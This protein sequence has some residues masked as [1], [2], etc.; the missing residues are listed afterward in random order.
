MPNILNTNADLEGRTLTTAE[1]NY[2]IDGLH[3]FDRGTSAPFAVVAGAAK[4]SNLDAD[5]LDGQTGA[6]YHD[7]SLLTGTYAALSGASITTLNA[8]NLASGTVPTARL[9]SGTAN[10]GTVLRGDQTYGLAFGLDI[11]NLRLSLTTATPVTTANV[12]AATTVY[13]ALYRGNRVALYTGTVWVVVSVAELTVAVPA[14]TVTPFDIFLDYNDGTPALST[15][16]WTNDTT[17]ATALT[18]QDGVYVK[19]GDTQQRYL[20]TGRTTGSSGQCED[21]FAKRFLWNYQNRVLREM[22]ALEGTDTWDYNTTTWRQA[23]GAAG[24][25]L[26]FVLGVAEVPLQAHVHAIAFNAGGAAVGFV[27]VGLDSVTVPTA[28]NIGRG[29]FSNATLSLIHQAHLHAYPAVGYHYAAWL[30]RGDGTGTQRW[31]GDNADSALYQSGIWGTIE[32]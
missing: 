31:Y 22:R 1:G 26:E 29:S 13:A 20:G 28:N 12:T 23:N 11:C 4:V 27:A 32:G 10:I 3:T 17:R 30:E 21:S 9:G 2:T 5:K 14:T 19:T 18:T 16:N 15:T 7:A 6:D 25:Q 8:S 24:N